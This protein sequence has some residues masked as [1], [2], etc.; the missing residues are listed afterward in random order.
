[1]YC[2]SDQASLC[3]EC[4]AKV[5]A[6]N[7]LVARHTRT[8][9]CHHCNA[10]TPWSASGPNLG[11][12][13]SV[14]H[15]C[16]AA[17]RPRKPDLAAGRPSLELSGRR[18]EDPRVEGAGSDGDRE[19]VVEEGDFDDEEEEEEEGDVEE[20]GDDEEEEDVDGEDEEE[21]GDNQVVPWSASPPPTASSSTSEESFPPYSSDTSHNNVKTPPSSKRM[22]DADDV[23]LLLKNPLLC[24][25]YHF[26][27]TK[28]K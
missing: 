21:E 18:R 13:L 4:D 12:T 25:L 7:F 20:D 16:V 9:L 24:F 19:D 2:E 10:P 15:L 8:L 17:R 11:P 23:S 3:W 1:M 26:Q 28:R 6:A 5:H 22:R 27:L 14:C